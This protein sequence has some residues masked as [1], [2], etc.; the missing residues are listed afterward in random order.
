MA[1]LKA[2]TNDFDIKNQE[3]HDKL[4]IFKTL[5][6]EHKSINKKSQYSGDVKMMGM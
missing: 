1:L 3:L 2:L 4:E 5:R 6:K